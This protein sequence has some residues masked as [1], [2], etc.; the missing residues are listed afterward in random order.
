MGQR[1]GT[2]RT[3]PEKRLADM[4]HD[5]GVSKDYLALLARQEK[6]D[7]EKG[8][9]GCWYGYQ[10]KIEAQLKKRWWGLKRRRLRALERLTQELFEWL[11]VIFAFFVV[12]GFAWLIYPGAVEI[13]GVREEIS[14][15]GRLGWSAGLA[16]LWFLLRMLA[17]ATSGIRYASLTGRE[18][19][20][21]NRS[22]WDLQRRVKDI[23]EREHPL[24]GKAHN[25]PDT[26][27]SGTDA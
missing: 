6:I 21:I 3:E 24:S 9:D 12:C 5:L 2:T 20:V 15:I 26:H 8:R 16:V 17:A 19:A 7:A 23:E 10:S 11:G 25:I 27:D 14:G 13:P 1:T 22:L 4:S 18:M